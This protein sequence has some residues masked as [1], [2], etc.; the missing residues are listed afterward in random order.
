MLTVHADLPIAVCLQPFI[1]ADVKFLRRQHQKLFSVFFKEIA[2]PDL[3]FVMQLRGFLFMTRK[4]LPIVRL[5]IIDMGYRH[6]QIRTVVAHFAF[7][8]SF[9]PAGVGIAEPN[10][11]MIVGTKPGKELRFMNRITD[12]PSDAGCIVKDQQRRHSADKFEDIQ[13]PLADAFGRL[14]AEQLTVPVVAVREGDGKVF[15]PA[16]FP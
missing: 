3:F 11:E 4:Q 14:T 1:P 5:H 10:T 12:P 6:K 9:L 8:I 15:F 16:E 13:K 2:D 7:Y